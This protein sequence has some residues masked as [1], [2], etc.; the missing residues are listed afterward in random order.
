MCNE[1]CLQCYEQGYDTGVRDSHSKLG[2]QI[3]E[4]EAEIGDLRQSLA[5]IDEIARKGLKW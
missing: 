1:R 5:D 3:R 4:L 2:V